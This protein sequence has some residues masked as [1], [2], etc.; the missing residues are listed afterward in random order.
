MN[1]AYIT[2]IILKM[3]WCYPSTLSHDIQSYQ[4]TIAKCNFMNNRDQSMKLFH[5]QIGLFICRINHLMS[6]HLCADD[7]LGVGVDIS[8]QDLEG[9]VPWVAP[10]PCPLPPGPG[11][12]C[13]QGDKCPGQHPNTGHQHFNMFHITDQHCVN[14]STLSSH[15]STNPQNMLS[16]PSWLH[17]WKL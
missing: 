5:I 15:V 7:G 2:Y 14:I 4:E 6:P 3:H 1:N 13:Q 16:V 8:W 11:S 12:Q 9:D 10:E 17:F